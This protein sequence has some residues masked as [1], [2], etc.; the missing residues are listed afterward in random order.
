MASMPLPS[1]GADYIVRGILNT[2][3]GVKTGCNK[4][5]KHVKVDMYDDDI[6]PDDYLGT[7]FTAANGFFVVVFNMYIENPDVYIDVHYKFQ[8]PDSRFVYVRDMG[9]TNTIV[10]EKP[11]NAAQTDGI[12][13]DI[14]PGNN[15]LGTINLPSNKANIGSQAT[16]CLRWVKSHSAGWNV[17]QDLI[18]YARFNETSSACAG[19]IIRIQKSDYDNPGLGNYAFSDIHHETGHWIAYKAYGNASPPGSGVVPHS[20]DMETNEGHAICEGWADYVAYLTAAPDNKNKF[21]GDF[22]TWWR[23]RDKTGTNNAGDIVEGAVWR[24]WATVGDFAG[25]FKTLRDDDPK[26][27]KKWVDGYGADKSWSINSTFQACQENGIVYTR[28]KITDF[29][30]GDPS[31][32]APASDGNEKKIG[33]ITFLRGEV[34]PTVVQ[35]T[36]AELNLGAKANVIAAAKKRLGYKTAAAGLAQTCQPGD[37]TFLGETAWT[38]DTVFNTKVVADGDYDLVIRA[39]NGHGWWDNFDPDFV[40]DS[41]ATRNSDEKWLKHLQTWYNQDA[42]PSD[43]KEG[44]VILDNTPPKITK[45]KPQ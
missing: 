7:D 27:F 11:G 16:D 17:P 36:K 10:D 38:A 26:H 1:D 42:S 9:T 37:W 6:G 45:R 43:D 20:N 33:D 2:S 5:A 44:K 24:I 15:N 40:G 31:D 22:K 8:A 32:N 28:A 13:E 12:W 39:E 19:D 34:K 35:N 21:T 18:A 14:P 41:T 3:V 30:E 23:G 29:P 4:P 25:T